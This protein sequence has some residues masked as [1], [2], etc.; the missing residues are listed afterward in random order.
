MGRAVGGSAEK[1]RILARA[2]GVDECDGHA[3][4]GFIEAEGSFNIVRN[5]GGRSWLCS[6]SLG[7]RADDA[8]M[9][10]DIA[11]V[12]G[13]GRL[14]PVAARRTSRRQV[15][16]SVSSKLE[17][18]ALMGLL[19]RYQLRGH[20]RRE[21]DVWAAAVDK[22]SESLYGASPAVHDLLRGAAADLRRLRRYGD[23]EDSGA[24]QPRSEGA[25]VGLLGFL[26]GFFSGEGSF[27]LQGRATAS[28]H[29]RADDAPL[30]EGFRDAF[31]VGRVAIG[32]SNGANPTVR[33][34][35]ARHAD[36]P[37]AI[38]IF[39][40]AVLRGR[41]RREFE[42]WR[43]GA[44]EYARGRDRDEAVISMAAT[45]LARARAYVDLPVALTTEVAPTGSYVDVLRA[46]A[47]EVAA[48]ELTCTAYA[49]AREGHPEWPTRNTIALAFGSWKRALDAAGLA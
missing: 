5:N 40:A 46:W 10:L 37:R 20:K 49:Q 8:D 35:I 18:R 26:G 13:L 38:A 33:W 4:A 42:A 36:L 15:V 41:K 48:G 2:Q 45:A 47:D 25:E 19:R 32:L 21:F 7:Q 43:V 30:L 28:V 6:M 24:E 23:H 22:W 1:A 34:T 17:C 14:Y 27:S 3:L 39:D 31:G 16:W 29:L 9:L 12:T 11:R 44:A